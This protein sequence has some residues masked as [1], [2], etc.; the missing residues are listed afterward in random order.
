M[1]E[2]KCCSKHSETATGT[3]DKGDLQE[4]LNIAVATA[5][6]SASGADRLI[7]WKLECVSGEEGGF[8][9]I[10]EMTVEISYEVV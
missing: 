10:S 4:A 9:G 8:V 2:K 6:S 5:L 3:S 1:S 7:K